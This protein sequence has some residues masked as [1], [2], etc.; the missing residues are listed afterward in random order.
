MPKVQEMVEK[1][2]K[3]RP[4]KAVNPDEAVAIGAAIQGSVLKGEIKGLL[5]HDIIPL[6]LGI[7]VIGG[8]FRR[9]VP[10]NTQ[11]PCTKTHVFTT[12]ENDQQF[13]NFQ[14]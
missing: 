13:I 5:L 4:S 7:E 14:I 2:F 11:I 3:K 1:F 12:V 8:I 9:I 10:K 6:S